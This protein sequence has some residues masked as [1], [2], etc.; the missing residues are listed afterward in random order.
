MGK[1]ILNKEISDSKKLILL[2]LQEL[3]LEKTDK[4][5][6]ITIADINNYLE[7]KEIMDGTNQEM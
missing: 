5:H 4:T 7:Q 3:F 2:Y 6:F 1:E